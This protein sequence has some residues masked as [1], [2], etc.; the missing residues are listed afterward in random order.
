MNEVLDDAS[1]FWSET[2]GYIGS[3]VS[4]I[5]YIILVLAAYRYSPTD[6]GA[7]KW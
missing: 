5:L 1:L 3:I 7:Y 6:M 4:V 2:V